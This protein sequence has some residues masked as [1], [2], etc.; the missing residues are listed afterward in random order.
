[1]SNSSYFDRPNTNQRHRFQ[2]D[3]PANSTLR[4]NFGSETAESSVSITHIPA[5]VS[6]QTIIAF[7]E[8]FGELS[9][10]PHIT[11]SD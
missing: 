4:P 7:A 2:Y 11:P 1:M 3:R 10:E 9:M 8:Q 5:A 6:R